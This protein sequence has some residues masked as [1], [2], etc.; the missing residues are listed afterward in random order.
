MNNILFIDIDRSGRYCH[1]EIWNNGHYIGNLYSYEG[2]WTFNV[3]GFDSETFYNDKQDAQE[4][5]VKLFE[6]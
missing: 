5:F 4:H 1:T 2:G 6:K 3:H